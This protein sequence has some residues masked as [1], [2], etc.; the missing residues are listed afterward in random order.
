[1][2][3]SV[4]L[5]AAAWLMLSVGNASAADRDSFQKLGGDT[6]AATMTLGFDGAADTTLA[7]WRHRY[8]FYRPGYFYWR[9]R[10][11]YAGFYPYAYYGYPFRSFA[12]G[13]SVS[14]YYYSYGPVYYAPGYSYYPINYTVPAPSTSVST[15]PA[16]AEVVPQPERVPPPRPAPGIFQYDGGPANPVPMPQTEPGP[17]RV[18]AKTIPA[19]GRFVSLPEQSSRYAYLAYGEKPQLQVS[20]KAV[21]FRVNLQAGR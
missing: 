14:P 17:I 1:M 5:G 15:K 11:F 16:A 21:Y 18:P 19:Q 13:F 7:T 10:V 6:R 2:V 12:F 4:M 8:G 3:R 20:E 9:P